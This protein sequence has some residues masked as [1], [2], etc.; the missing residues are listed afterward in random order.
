MKVFR[1]LVTSAL[2]LIIFTSCQEDRDDNITNV[3]DLANQENIKDYIWKAMNVFYV[4]KSDAPDLADE[5]FDNTPDYREFLNS[6]D[7]PIDFFNSLLQFT[8]NCNGV[9]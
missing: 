9:A 7:S 8:L 5:R 4:Y 2:L 3:N 6:I 1:F